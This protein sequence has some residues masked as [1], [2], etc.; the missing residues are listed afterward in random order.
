MNLNHLTFLRLVGHL[1]LNL[2]FQSVDHWHWDLEILLK[3]YQY[4]IL[5][6]VLLSIH[7]R[8]ALQAHLTEE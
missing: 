4:Q 2:D 3:I 5:H 6:P 7:Q 1:E 8:R